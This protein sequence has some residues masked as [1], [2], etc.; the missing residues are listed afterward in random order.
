M[1][2]K[3]D[4]AAHSEVTLRLAKQE[5]AEHM[6]GM[7]AATDEM[8]QQP[9]IVKAYALNDPNAPTGDNV[10][11][12]HFVRHGQGFHNLMADRAKQS[13]QK[14]VNVRYGL[15]LELLYSIT[16]S[17][18][19][20]CLVLF[21]S[22]L[23]VYKNARKSLLHSGNFGCPAYGERAQ[24]GASVA[25]DHSRNGASTRTRRF[26]SELPCPSN[27]CYGV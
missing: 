20:C 24:T 15:R 22:S 9:L 14:W 21:P 8:R 11:T 12:V 5:H 4:A 7:Q 10:K 1:T 3:D 23:T 6:E 17:Q 13:G 27:R 25:T 26:F 16:V 19:S 18:I 2:P